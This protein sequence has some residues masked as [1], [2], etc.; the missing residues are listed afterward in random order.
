MDGGIFVDRKL[1][2]PV[3]SF[4][5][6][7]VMKKEK[8]LIIGSGP[9]G[10]TAAIYAARA[11]LAPVVFEGALPGGQLMQT[12][13]VENFPG[14]PN[15]IFGAELMQNMRE[16]SKKFGAKPVNETVTSVDFS[17]PE[18]LKVKTN[19]EE[20]EAEAVIIATGAKARWLDFLG[21]K[22]RQSE[23]EKKYWG[24]GY[25]A[26]ATCDGAFFRGKTVAVAGGG[27]SACEEA[28]FLTRFAE[29]VYLIHR[30][31]ELRASKPMQKRVL[32]HE[33]IEVLWNK[34][35]SNIWGDKKVEGIE[36]V[37][38][39]TDETS[40]LKLDGIF[41]A[42]GHSPNTQFLQ[43][44]IDLL[45]NGYAHVQNQT[46][47]NVPSVFVAGDVSDYHYRQAITAAGAGCMAAMD[48]EKFL[49]EKVSSK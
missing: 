18:A 39:V 32:E 5:I 9:A 10:F 19:V 43:G 45:E 47:T 15:G 42:I 48:V 16:Q 13:E 49:E 23:L 25:T 17:C 3:T 12:S 20:Y 41:V 11:D 28:T 27:D 26:C 1:V 36:L 44:Q 35:I 34:N 4:Y 31:D 29:K 22:Q 2:L 14:F 24:K 21:N 30:R 6:W 38:S 37:D 46:R 8:L 40:E 33:K 7:H